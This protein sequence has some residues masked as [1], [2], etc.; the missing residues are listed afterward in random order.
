MWWRFWKK[1]RT[2]EQR[3]HRI[4]SS[5][6]P[7]P[8]KLRQHLIQELELN[9]QWVRTLASVTRPMAGERDIY[10]FRVFSPN[11]MTMRGITVRDYG[12]LEGCGHLILFSGTL[13]LET[14][15]VSLIPG[16][17][18]RGSGP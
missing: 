15:S 7:L 10:E 18:A 11:Q 4:P 17:Q 12:S 2:R 14:G 1:T 13:N 3:F 8:K 9:A 5:P 16:V 6:G